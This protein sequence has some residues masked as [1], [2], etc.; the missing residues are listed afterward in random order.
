MVF[1]KGDRVVNKVTGAEDIVKSVPGMREYD[2]HC[3]IDPETGFIL[4]DTSWNRQEN[5]KLK[6]EKMEFKVGDRVVCIKAVNGVKVGTEGRV[7]SLESNSQVGIEWDVDIAEGH[8][9]DGKGRYGHC[10]FMFLNTI[11]LINE[12]SPFITLKDL[13]E[14]RACRDGIKWFAQRYADD[15]VL[16]EDMF[17]A[18]KEDGKPSDW[19]GWIIKNFNIKEKKTYKIGEKFK[20][21]CDKYVLAYSG[22]GKYAL[23]NL[24]K[25]TIWNDPKPAGDRHAITEEEMSEITGGSEFE[26]VG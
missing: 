9:C 23:V 3:F 14:K 1:K 16:P 22:D 2:D 18:F 20:V 13:L 26:K 17:K 24:E 4:K 12:N 5:W 25:G 11:K 10:W 15:P 19:K 8:S 6:E 7:L 21:N